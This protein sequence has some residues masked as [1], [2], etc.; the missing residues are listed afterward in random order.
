MITKS[1]LNPV[2][3]ERTKDG[4]MF[5]DIPSRLIKDRVI[6]LS[7]PITSDV[8]GIISPLLFM[9]NTENP[10]EKISLWL[11]TPGGDAHAFLA[12][13]DMMQ[14]VE[15]PVETVCIGNAM[16][17]GALLLAAGS[18]GMRL[19]TPNSKIM[20][21][22]IQIGGIYGSGTDVQIESKEIENLNT[23]VLEILARHSGRTL[24]EVRAD[25]T[26][27]KYLSAQEAV[28]YGI[29]DKV[30]PMHKKIPALKKSTVKK[31]T[32]KRK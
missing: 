20:I 19:A 15:A 6:F 22:Q 24:A 25:C 16:S 21:H 30:L 32:S 17:A 29:V 4:E 10:K 13:Y 28:K 5:Y 11:N 18:K 12:I 7:E 8:A 1:L 3:Y 31:E 26:H 2:Y 23:K 27:N 9:M 14:L